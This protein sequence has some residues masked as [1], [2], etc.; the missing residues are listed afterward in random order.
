MVRYMVRYMV[1]YLIGYMGVVVNRSCKRIAYAPCW[2]ASFVLICAFAGGHK[3]PIWGVFYT[4]HSHQ[5]KPK[6]YELVC[7]VGTF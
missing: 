3:C 2:Y 4:P 6:I 5:L 7:P 1:G